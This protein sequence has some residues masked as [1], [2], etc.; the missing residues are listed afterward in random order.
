[1]LLKQSH[2]LI[3]EICKVDHSLYCC[4]HLLQPRDQFIAQL[5]SSLKLKQQCTAKVVGTNDEEVCESWEDIE[6][7]EVNR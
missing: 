2:H 1:V 3:S 6:N 4:F 5:M 7:E